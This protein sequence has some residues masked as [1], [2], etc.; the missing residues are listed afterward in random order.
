MGWPREKKI[1]C[2]KEYFEM[3]LFEIKKTERGKKM[4]SRKEKPTTAAQKKANRKRSIR[5]LT[6]LVY[7][8]F[9]ARDYY[10]TLTCEPEHMPHDKKEATNTL[11]NYIRRVNRRL[12]KM[13]KPHAKYICTIESGR[14]HDNYHF[15]F[16][17]S[18]GLSRDELEDIWGIG[19]A[20]ARRL[21]MPQVFML[22]QYLTKEVREPNEKSWHC[23]RNLKKPTIRKN[24]FRYSHR[25]M[26]N[27]AHNVDDRDMWEKLYPGYEYLEA[28]ATFSDEQGWYITLRM[29]RR[30]HVP[31]ENKTRPSK[32]D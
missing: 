4:R 1:F 26:E 3:D 29:K 22:A 23:S 25:Q 19:L 28:H 24:D 16:V 17:I 9:D 13:G 11:R 31:G 27:M 30:E 2:G 12:E 7:T 15:H 21:K 10:L 32:R 8:N 20:N 14:N 18:C 5:E 6:W